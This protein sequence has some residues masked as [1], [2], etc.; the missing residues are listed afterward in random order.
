MTRRTVSGILAAAVATAGTFTVGYPTGTTRGDFSTGVSHKLSALGAIFSAPEDMTLSF[1]A[2][3]VTVTYNGATTLPAGTPFTFQFD[4]LG[5]SNPVYDAESGVALYTPCV[6]GNLDLGSPGAPDADGYAASQSIAAAAD[7]DLNGAL[8]VSDVGIADA[9]TGRNVV[10][11]WTT[12]SVVTVTGTDM[13]GEEMVEACASGTTFTGKK[14]FKEITSIS[15][16]AAIT[17][18]TFGTGDVIGL[19][20]YVPNAS[21]ILKESIDGAA[22]T[23][24]TIVAGLTLATKPTATNADVRGT[25]D[26]NSATDGSR[27]FGLM[28]AL[29]DPTFLGATQY[30]A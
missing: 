2:S 8:V 14:A 6:L 30:T 11:A 23:A 16:S 27:A 18:A 24:G 13:Y 22:A 7:A 15:S 26:P 5:A 17:A 12:A 20:V 4:R 19:P 29:P 28:T 1:G 21:M 25:Y 3:S 10:G 9:R